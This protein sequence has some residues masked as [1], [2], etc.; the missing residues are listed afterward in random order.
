MIQKIRISISLGLSVAIT[1]F[2][3]ITSYHFLVT[4]ISILNSSGTGIH[5]KIDTNNVDYK[6]HHQK[7]KWSS[8]VIN[9]IK[10]IKEQYEND[11]QHI[12]VQ[13]KLIT[14]REPIFNNLS[15]PTI[16]N[17][18]LILQE[19]FPGYE[20]SILDVWSRMDTYEQWL[21]ME[22]RTLLEL[23]ALERS[24]MLWHKRKQLF[25]NSA[26]DIWGEEL[27]NYEEAQLAFHSEVDQLDR[28]LD[29]SMY[30]RIQRL[31]QSFTQA[32]NLISMVTD[33]QD[34][35][36]NSTIASVLFGLASVQQELQQLD[37]IQRQEEI[38][39]VRRELGYDEESI[40][41]MAQVDTKRDQRWNNGYAYMQSRKILLASNEHS[42]DEMM[43][44]R[45]QYFG[46]S[47][48]TIALEEEQGFY[49]FQRPRYFGRN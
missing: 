36:H 22:N 43:D 30:D 41:K 16:D 13:A 20:D 3:V 23:N 48:K 35:I 32:N 33:K 15:A 34:G 11:I 26:S 39:S 27:N 19:A 1:S 44:L 12:P 7:S 25:P 42:N 5:N 49:R 9:I 29:I 24:G 31:K 18:R 8:A 14:I 2:I 28:S 37:P 38:N 4:P 17:L 21:T 45:I 6:I 10:T 47:A 40:Q 46:N